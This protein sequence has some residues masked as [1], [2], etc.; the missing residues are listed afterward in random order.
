MKV[1]TLPPL[2][3]EATKHIGVVDKTFA[4]DM[5]IAFGIITTTDDISI[6][7]HC[8]RFCLAVSIQC[9]EPSVF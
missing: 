7:P 3:Y 6:R 1:A 4:D 9:R 8:Q 5:Q 2:S